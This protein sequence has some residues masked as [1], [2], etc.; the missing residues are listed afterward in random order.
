MNDTLLA[1]PRDRYIE[2][3]GL[4]LHYAEWGDPEQETLLLV[5][6][7]RD[8]CR[9][10]DFFVAEVF[11]LNPL[12]HIMALDLCGH[13]ESDWNSPQH[14][15]RHED[16]I[17]DLAAAF[18]STGKPKINLI[19]HSL[20]GSMSLLFTGCFPDRVKNLVVVESIGPYAKQDEEIPQIFAEA[21][22]GKQW[23]LER[24]AHT[25]LEEAAQTLKKRFPSIP[26]A[27]CAYM[28]SFGTSKTETGYIWKHDPR[29]R[30]HSLAALS[31]GQI[32]AFIRRVSC[33]TMIVYGGGSGFTKSPR[34]ARL[35]LLSGEKVEFPATGHHVPH[36]RPAELAQTVCRFLFPA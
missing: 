19:G 30:L 35:S 11:R 14:G 31:E 2:S 34:A 25:S 22:D 9:S 29:L 7:N 4:K 5:H 18:Q 26:D 23:N 10:W 20:G 21:L 36:E 6:G 24:T 33:P 1:Q 3:R 32:R 8:Q 17:A 12:L 13:G 15:Y 16:F 27:M 28:A